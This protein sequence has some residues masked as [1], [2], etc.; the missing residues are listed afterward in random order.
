MYAPFLLMLFLDS[1]FGV[2][3]AVVMHCAQCVLRMRC[4]ATWYALGVRPAAKHGTW[5]LLR[6]LSVAMRC[7]R[8][9]LPAGDTAPPTR[10]PSRPGSRPIS[11]ALRGLS[12]GRKPS[13]TEMTS[14]PRT[15][16]SP[17]S[18][19]TTS[20]PSVQDDTPRRPRLPST[21]SG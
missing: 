2:V 3:L 18:V 1:F 21:G 10:R 14:P 4:T 5:C 11:Q 16:A 20:P 7:A 12:I 13:R 15:D 19:V 17:F 9:L 6:V 8:F